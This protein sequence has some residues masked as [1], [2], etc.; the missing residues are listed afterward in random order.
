MDY[1]NKTLD[2]ILIFSLDQTYKIFSRCCCAIFFQVIFFTKNFTKLQLSVVK[3]RT[4]L[5]TR[6][7]S[8]LY[9]RSL[10]QTTNHSKPI[11][12]PLLYRTRGEDTKQCLVSKFHASLFK[13]ARVTSLHIIMAYDNE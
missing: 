10:N 1:I 5:V 7:L 11:L 8:I 6:R 2:I 13:L 3:C 4:M 12:I 9:R